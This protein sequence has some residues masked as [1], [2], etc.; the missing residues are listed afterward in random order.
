MG[1]FR[2]DRGNKKFL[3]WTKIW[4]LLKASPLLCWFSLFIF[5]RIW[6]LDR[7]TLL[8]HFVVEFCL[9]ILM[10]SSFRSVWS[11]ETWLME[12]E[13][14]LTVVSY[15]PHVSDWFFTSGEMRHDLLFPLNIS[16]KCYY[17]DDLGELSSN[18][19]SYQ[20]RIN[21]VL[22][23]RFLRQGTLWHFSLQI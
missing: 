3:D 15:F 13:F 18:Q 20:E 8:P 6:K 19:G 12:L 2:P 16:C 14:K 1:D 22:R 7:S 17:Y 9:S 23:R 4:K 5:F 11:H 21:D 10:W